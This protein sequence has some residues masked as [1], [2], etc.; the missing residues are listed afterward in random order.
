MSYRSIFNCD[1]YSA[2]DVSVQQR[3]EEDI[4]RLK[5]EHFENYHVNFDRESRD[6][7]DTC[8]TSDPFYVRNLS[9]RIEVSSYDDIVNFD[10]SSD[11]LSGEEEEDLLTVEVDVEFR[12]WCQTNRDNDIVHKSHTFL[13]RRF[14][15]TGLFDYDF[16]TFVHPDNGFVIDKNVIMEVVFRAEPVVY[17]TM[18]PLSTPIAQEIIDITRDLHKLIHLIEDIPVHFK[19]H[20]ITIPGHRDFLSFKSVVLK[21]LMEDSGAF[22]GTCQEPCEVV[23]PSKIEVGAFLSVLRFMYHK[24]VCLRNDDLKAV[25]VAADF[26]HV[27]DLTRYL[28]S[29]LNSQNILRNYKCY[30][31]EM[32]NPFIY[33]YCLRTIDTEISD[34][35]EDPEEESFLSVER[36][37]LEVILS[38]DSLFI[39][40]LDLFNACLSWMTSQCKKQNLEVNA[41]NRRKVFGGCADLIRFPCMS[42]ENFI[43][44][45]P[46]HILSLEEVSQVFLFFVKESKPDIKYNV[47]ERKFKRHF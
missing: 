18:I 37:F 46:S 16:A 47:Q 26:F 31:D 5:D 7:H 21:Q 1:S 19:V 24:K 32:T 20:G 25:L 29:A 45:I 14:D 10:V 15:V 36:D 12:I 42:L 2:D 33:Q 23:I 9:W 43:S 41:T 3:E 13:D 28:L 17:T 6:Y 39:E 38:R 40:E 27:D 4:D 11:E 35:L 34:V 8:W 30:R 22:E 44:T